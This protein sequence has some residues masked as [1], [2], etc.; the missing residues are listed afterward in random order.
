MMTEQY[1]NIE[2]EGTVADRFWTAWKKLD[3]KLPTN[4]ELSYIFDLTVAETTRFKV[5]GREYSDSITFLGKS[6]TS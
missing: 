4:K 3:L 6:S 2:V 5:P 1:Y